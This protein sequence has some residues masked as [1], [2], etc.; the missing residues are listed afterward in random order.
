VARVL[1]C[2][3]LAYD[4][5]GRFSGRLEAHT[6]NVKLD[7]MVHGFGG[8]AMNMAY[9]L[10]QLGHE[11]VPLVYAGDNFGPDYEQHLSA[12]GISRDGIIQVPGIDCARGLILTDADGAQFTA[13]YPGPTGLER[14]HRDLAVFASK[15]YDGL[16]IAPDLP[17]KML[18]C[19]G[20]FVRIK[21]RVWCPGQ[22]AEMLSAAEAREMLRSIDILIANRHEWDALCH[23]L[24]AAEI[25][26]QLDEVVITDGPHPVTAVHQQLVV[27]VPQTSAVDPTGCGDAFAAA[28]VAAT[29]E[30][31]DLAEAL[32]AGISQ[33]S[34]CLRTQGSQQ[35]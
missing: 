19:A 3:T 33:A 35:H 9:N 11:P 28:L 6:R 14:H 12:L 23:R 21:L 13:F 34:L 4:L 2:G 16:I 30:S 5:I 27:Q 20:A 24:P 17:E 29:L 32:R 25:S 26:R 7:S 10:R 8:C 1:I 18:A 22:Y 15:D 31:K